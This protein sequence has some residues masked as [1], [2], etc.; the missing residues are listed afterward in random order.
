MN[1]SHD[2]ITD[3]LRQADPVD[4]NQLPSPH[5]DAAQHQLSAIMDSSEVTF[6]ALPSIPRPE[7]Y[8][9]RSRLLLAGAAAAVVLLVAGLTIFTPGNTD[10]AL[11]VV[12]QAAETTA[13]TMSGRVTT[14]F[15]LHGIDG[16]VSEQIIGRAEALFSGADVALSVALSDETSLDPTEVPSKAEMRLVDN[17]L[18]FNNGSQ[19][20]TTEAPALVSETVIELADPRAV[21]SIVEGL[22]ESEE[23]GS[24]DLNGVATTHF[25]S[26]LDLDADSVAALPLGALNELAAEIDIEGVVDVDLYVDDAGLLR[27]LDLSGDLNQPEDDGSGSATFEVV[28]SFSDLG[29]DLTIEAPAEAIELNP[30]DGLD[31][32]AELDDDDLDG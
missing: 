30:G 12:Q 29:A 9:H 2:D 5:G 15:S 6:A 26:S 20:F 28:T 3:R 25:R 7:R 16:G 27:R 24:V 19:W 21:L 10:P 18:Y 11:A 32:E 22:I 4:P 8:R 13:E 31:L 1:E 23:V 17:D 14:T